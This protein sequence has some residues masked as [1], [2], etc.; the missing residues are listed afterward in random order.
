MIILSICISAHCTYLLSI[1][2]YQIALF[3][4]ENVGTNQNQFWIWKRDFRFRFTWY[5]MAG[6]Q[7]VEISSVALKYVYLSLIQLPAER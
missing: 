4:R 5:N 6:H 1:G 2:M 7:L 3:S